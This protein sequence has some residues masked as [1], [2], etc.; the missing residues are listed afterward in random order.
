MWDF[1]VVSVVL[2]LLPGQVDI[3]VSGVC[4]GQ[5]HLK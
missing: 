3:Q 1:P 5:L 2:M 4:F